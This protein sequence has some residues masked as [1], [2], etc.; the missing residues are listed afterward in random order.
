MLR[1]RG[2]TGARASLPHTQGLVGLWWRELAKGGQSA[3]RST[4]P[5]GNGA[6]YQAGQ[7]G[8]AAPRH[9]ARGNQE[10]ISKSA[11]EWNEEIKSTAAEGKQWETKSKR[12]SKSKRREE[13]SS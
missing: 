9:K 3:E 13:H 8:Q 7:K 12:K 4:T 1:R 2:S 5:G 11:L 10:R 6:G